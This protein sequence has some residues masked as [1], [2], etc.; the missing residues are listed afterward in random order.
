MFTVCLIVSDSLKGVAVVGLAA[1]PL[2]L[3][4]SIG[5]NQPLCVL[6]VRC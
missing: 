3:M 6:V 1:H 5:T 4:L 2:A